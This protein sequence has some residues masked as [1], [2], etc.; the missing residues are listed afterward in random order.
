MPKNFGELSHQVQRAAVGR[1]EITMQSSGLILID[2]LTENNLAAFLASGLESVVIETSPKNFQALLAT[3]PGWS[4]D[5]IRNAQRALAARFGGDGNATA[6][7]QLHRLPGSLNQ[8]NGGLF[9]T[10]LHT[11]QTGDLIEPVDTQLTAAASSSGQS[12]QHRSTSGCDITPS[13]SD[14]GRACQLISAGASHDV[15]VAEIARRA[16]ERSRRGDHLVYAQRTVQNA[17]LKLQR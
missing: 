10:R 14:F 11:M 2:D 17:V 9:V 16:T 4:V 8:K 7:R 13:G 1:F 5:Q 12:A 15:V 6:A 3:R